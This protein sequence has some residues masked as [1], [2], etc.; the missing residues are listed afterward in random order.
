MLGRLANLAIRRGG[1]VL[2]ASLFIGAF[3][4]VVGGPVAD[5]LKGGGFEDPGS[6]ST[7]AR[8]NI[9]AATQLDNRGLIV[10]I[11]PNADVTTSAD[12][13]AEIG[14]V[15]STLKAEAAVG[16]V[17]AW[18][19]SV[20]QS[21]GLLS[22][23]HHS[24]Y[25]VAYWHAI[26]EDA[27]YQVSQR[28]QAQF[29]DNPHLT[30]GG[31][32]VA[33]HQVETQVS[34][35]LAH[36][37]TLAFPLLFVLLIFVFRGAVAAFLPLL[38]GGLSIVI[39]FLA[40]R[41][42]VAFT[43]LSIFALNIVTGLGLG[44]AI[45]YSLL[46]VSRYREESA[47]DGPGL[48]AM[49]RT[50]AT[51]GRTVIFSS[52][53]VAAALAS[54]LVFP[55]RFLYSMGVGGVLVTII[56]ALVALTV[57]PAALA[58]LGPRVD[59]LSIRRQKPV[60]ADAKGAWYR[61]A[62]YVM[63]CPVRIALATAAILLILGV[64]FLRIQFTSV[65]ASVLPSTFSAKQVDTALRNDF[66]PFSVSPINVVATTDQAG[67]E[68]LATQISGVNGIRSVGAP[69]EL[70][71]GMWQ[72]DAVLSS[73]PLSPT[74]VHALEDVRALPTS[75]PVI[76]GGQTATFADLQLSLKDHLPLTFAIIALATLLIL[77]AATGS[78]VLPI[79]ALIMNLLSLSATLGI[80]VL[81]F[82]DGRFESLLG[83]TGQGALESTQPVILFAIAFGLSTDYGVFLLTRIKE[84]RDH[85]LDN[86]EAVATGL[87]RTG[88]IVTMAAMLFCVA[89]GAFATSQI[90]F[91][92]ELGIGTAFAVLIDAS[93]VRALLVPALMALLGEW[94]WWAPSPMRALHK[95]LR[96]DRLE[97][98]ET[99]VQREAA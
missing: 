56:A 93:I 76:T 60:A 66:P 73:D 6:Q 19:P 41:T 89:I 86:T 29:K 52:L 87:E 69:R 38:V 79:K 24:T 3:S 55:E 23:D 57:L 10:L 80:L 32:T 11:R 21:A 65:D 43:D 25:V 62:H 94:N 51:A 97:G 39:T 7:V 68:T 91:I 70:S 26:G 46:I 72:I 9:A 63:R 22:A 78:V 40:L 99:A 77:F 34:A 54:L 27:E 1:W 20:P 67:A 61:L 42:T 81:I 50:L 88:R 5:K 28:L 98:G 17:V 92:K 82:Q 90:I 71:A 16:N 74:A 64:P 18:S 47:V 95:K 58:V 84:A 45:D 48:P 12:A 15:V 13:Q 83:Y 2:I 44:L 31:A 14:K 75:F 49:R 53:T 96:L 85:G 36:A 35:D 8:D 33:E 59:S 37:E 4:G 30:V